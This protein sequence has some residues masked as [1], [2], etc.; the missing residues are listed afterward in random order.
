MFETLVRDA[1]PPGLHVHY[2][3]AYRTG[4][5]VRWLSNGELEFLGRIDRQVKINGVRIELGEVEAALNSAPSVTNAVAVA[6]LPEGSSS[7]RLVGYVV[8]AAVDSATVLAHCRER[9]LPSMVPSAIVV[10]DAFPLLPSGK[11]SMLCVDFTQS[12]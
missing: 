2:E 3:R 7:K 4:D 12:V 1:T 8:P 9:L 6:I 5:L 11:V 10:L